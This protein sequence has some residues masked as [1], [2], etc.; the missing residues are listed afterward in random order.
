MYVYT[1]IDPYVNNEYTLVNST[2][3]IYKSYVY[4][5]AHI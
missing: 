2:V 1:L 3:Y 5:Q 4:R